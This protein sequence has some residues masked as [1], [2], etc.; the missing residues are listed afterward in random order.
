ML[1]HDIATMYKV[2]SEKY[3]DAMPGKRP[4]GSTLFYSI[5][6]NITGGGKKQ[7][8]GAGVDYIKV[9]FHTDNFALVD[10]IIDV[11]A[12]LSDVNHILH[13][14][15]HGLCSDVYTFLSY[16]YAVHV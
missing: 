1:K 2:Y 3:K 8:A 14:E 9:N 15:L 7:E 16:G 6:K 10:K 13:D 12:P 5:A 4:I 11:L